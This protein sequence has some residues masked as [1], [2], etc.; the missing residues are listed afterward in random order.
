MQLI[1]IILLL[2]TWPQQMFAISKI[3]VAALQSSYDLLST[4]LSQVRGWLLIFC[5]ATNAASNTIC[6]RDTHA[7][8]VVDRCSTASMPFTSKGRAVG[9][10][11]PLLPVL[12][13]QQQN[14]L[15]LALILRPLL[16]WSASSMLMAISML[17]ADSDSTTDELPHIYTTRPVRNR[18]PTHRP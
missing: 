2:I 15:Y 3:A 4:E 17:P 16:F 1:V 13:A 7:V 12:S 6:W 9:D 5:I 11:L 10:T 8:A 14:M 18:H